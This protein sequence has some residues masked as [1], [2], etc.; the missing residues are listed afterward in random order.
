[1]ESDALDAMEPVALST[2]ASTG[3]A[4]KIKTKLPAKSKV[5][6]NCARKRIARIL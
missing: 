6:I 3:C 5:N 4:N 1:L 2:A